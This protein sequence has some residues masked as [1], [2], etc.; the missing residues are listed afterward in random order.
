[1]S[2]SIL[3]PEVTVGRGAKVLKAIIEK[4]VKIPEGEEIG[5]DLEK[6]AKRFHVTPSGIVV[7]GKSAFKSQA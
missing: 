3:F 5:V 4:G 1:V 7:L 6:D 2:E